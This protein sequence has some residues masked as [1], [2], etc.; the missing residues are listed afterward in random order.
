MSGY[1]Y[2]ISIFVILGLLIS[3]DFRSGL[4]QSVGASIVFT[5]PII[6]GTLYALFIHAIYLGIKEKNLLLIF[7]LWK[8]YILGVYSVIGDF[9]KYGF[10]Y[11]YDELGNVAGGE[12]I[13]DLIGTAE[14][15]PLGE[16]KTTISASIGYYEYNSLKLI[17]F[18]LWLSKALNTVF[19]QTRHTIGSWEKKLAIEEIEERNLHG[20]K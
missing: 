12:L 11:R 5:I 10:A 18:G 1:I 9:L 20:N 2:L 6:V 7:G 19:N 17:G 8:R 16:S 13:E 15:T 4:I 3:K 14:N